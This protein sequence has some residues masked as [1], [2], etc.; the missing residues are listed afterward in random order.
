MSTVRRGQL[1]LPRPLSGLRRLELDDLDAIL[2]SANAVSPALLIV[3]SIQTVSVDEITSAAGSVS[4][5]RECTARLLQWGKSRN[6]PVFIIG[7]VTKEGAI[8]GPRVLE[9]IVD[10][11]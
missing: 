3:D 1:G 6:I 9:H 8:A 5:V 10:A 7:H 4:Q 11:V 2:A